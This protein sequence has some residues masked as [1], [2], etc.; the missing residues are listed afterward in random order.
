M[1]PQFWLKHNHIRFFPC[2]L[3]RLQRANDILSTV[4]PHFENLNFIS[5][6]RTYACLIFALR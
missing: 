4:S 6:L 1:F 3:L 2:I 5:L